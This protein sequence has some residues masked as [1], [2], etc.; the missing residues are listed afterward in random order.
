MYQSEFY[1]EMKPIGD[2]AGYLFTYLCQPEMC[3]TGWQTG[4]SGRR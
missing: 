1:G 3:T 4:N 2:I